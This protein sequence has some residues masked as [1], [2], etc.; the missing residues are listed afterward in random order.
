MTDIKLL[1]D[2]IDQLDADIIQ[3]LAQR[4]NCARKIGQLKSLHSKEIVD[5]DREAEIRLHH[6]ALAKQYQIDSHFIQQLFELIV[7]HSRKVQKG[8]R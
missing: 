3:R 4:E 1:R 2:E 7:L 6:D 8:S 5:L